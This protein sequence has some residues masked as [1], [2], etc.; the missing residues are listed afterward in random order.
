MAS[1]SRPVGPGGAMIQFSRPAVAQAPDTTIY[2]VD[3]P[4]ATA[5]YLG[6]SRVL[7]LD[8]ATGVI[9]AVQWLPRVVSHHQFGEYV[10]SN[11]VSGPIVGEDGAA[12]TRLERSAAE[13]DDH[14]PG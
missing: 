14:P 7:A 8:G 9:R 11:R 3:D 5:N 12:Q 13:P 10:V 4:M 6:D 1:F 2:T